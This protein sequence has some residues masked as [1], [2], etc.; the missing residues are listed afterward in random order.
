MP[1]R[2]GGFKNRGSLGAGTMLST[3]RFAFKEW[4]VTLRALAAGRQHLLLRKGGI[5]EEGGRF[6]PEH[7]E[8]WLF[9]THF[10]QTPDDIRPEALPFLESIAIETPLPGSVNLSL[11][12][13]VLEVLQ[14]TDESLLPRLAKLQILAEPVLAQRFHYRRPGLYVLPVRI[15]ARAEPLL[16]AESPHFAGCRTWVDVGEELSTEGLVPVLSDEAHRDGVEALRASL[17]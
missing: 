3:N 15:Y 13:V 11:Y 16:L 14:I 8:F 2:F 12:A 4:A 6:E 1:S 17:H 7:A 10:H 5:H 9:P